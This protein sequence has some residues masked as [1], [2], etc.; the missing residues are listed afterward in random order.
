M[1]MTRRPAF[2]SAALLCTACFQAGDNATSATEGASAGSSSTTHGGTNATSTS[3]GTSGEPE[4]STG[5]GST[6]AGSSSSSATDDPMTT[7]GDPDTSI[8]GNGVVEGVEQCDLG[9]E[10]ADEGLCTTACEDARCGDGVLQPE[11]GEACD[12]GDELNDD[13]AACLS[14]C[15]KATCGDGKKWL[16]VEECDDGP[17]NQANLYDGCTPMT[18]TKGPHCGDKI[19]QKPWE[20]CDLGE[21]NGK[22]DGPCS[23]M[24]T[25]AGKLVFITSKTYTG[26][27]GLGGTAAAD[28]ACNTVAMEAGLA[29]AGNFRAW[30]SDADS[31]PSTWNPHPEG[32]F[33]LLGPKVIATSWDELLD[34]SLNAK[35]NVLETGASVGDQTPV[36]WTGTGASGQPLAENC[37]GWTSAS[38]NHLG[39]QGSLDATDAAWTNFGAIQCWRSGR[40][41]CIE[42]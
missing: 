4:I 27:I 2:L 42:Q 10:N 22:Q 29:N 8:C 16:G 36:A 3:T 13:S 32:P 9:E 14:N 37:A 33:I 20:E 17:M 40:L 38:P 11:A 6:S 19:L 15:K 23:A 1:H 41:I 28:D 39:R 35:A 25:L 31:S 30:I 5:E 21:D 12:F 34:G 24:C 18:C 26:A 7:S